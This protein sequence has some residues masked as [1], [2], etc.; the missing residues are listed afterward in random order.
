[1]LA[2]APPPEKKTNKSKS[3]F[4]FY[5]IIINQ[6][7]DSVQK[8]KAFLKKIKFYILTKFALTKMKNAK[9]VI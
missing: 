8:M 2:S 6:R 1:M 7:E 9:N 4:K 3:L 5:T